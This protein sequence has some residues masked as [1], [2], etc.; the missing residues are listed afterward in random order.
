MMGWII[1]RSLIELV[2]SS[3]LTSSNFF[4]GWYLFLTSELIETFFLSLIFSLSP[5]KDDNPLPNPFFDLNGLI[6][7][8]SPLVYLGLKI[9]L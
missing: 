9:P 1:P 6:M 7:L 8:H 5:I 3:K 2:N 4:L